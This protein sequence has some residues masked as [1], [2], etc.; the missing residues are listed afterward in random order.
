M[1]AR[2]RRFVEGC[3]SPEAVAELYDDLFRRVAGG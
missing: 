1:G 2:A 3:H